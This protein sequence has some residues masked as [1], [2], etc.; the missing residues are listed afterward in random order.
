[1][2]FAIAM[3]AAGAAEPVM[4]LSPKQVREEVR[5]V[6]QGQLAA[7][8]AGDFAT[9]YG[10]AAAG[11]KARFDDQVFAAMIRRGYPLLLQAKE[12]EL[13][14]V[15]DRDGELAEVTVSVRDR[16]KH[17]VVYRYVLVH[18]PE[19]WRITAVTLEQRPARGDI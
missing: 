12:A 17:P 9:A 4:R 15:H 13:G 8:R 5:T 3:L 1:M 18:E 11:L 10:Y 19:G 7:L 2:L 14:V 16:Q 6:V